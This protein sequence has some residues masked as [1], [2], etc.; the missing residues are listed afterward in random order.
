[1]ITNTHGSVRVSGNFHDNE[2]ESSTDVSRQKQ[3]LV[4]LGVGSSAG[5]VATGA[6]IL[7]FER[8]GA[9]FT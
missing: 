3:A 7:D 6:R 8:M 2:P 1:M 5:G 4:P 9:H